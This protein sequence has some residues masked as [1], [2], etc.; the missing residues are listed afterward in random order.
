[1]ENISVHDDGNLRNK[2]TDVVSS[3][4]S[5]SIYEALEL[6]DVGSDHLEKGVYKVRNYVVSDMLSDFLFV[7]PSRFNPLWKISQAQ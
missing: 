4:A 3:G 1:M 7:F 2:V 5:I 6:M